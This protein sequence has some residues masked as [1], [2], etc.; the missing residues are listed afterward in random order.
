MTNIIEPKA[1]KRTSARHR[2][3]KGAQISFRGLHAAIDCVV[4]DTSDGGA[5]LAVES[6]VG[7]PDRFDLVRENL[8]TKKCQVVWRHATQ[9]GAKFI[10]EAAE[11]KPAKLRAKLSSP[12]E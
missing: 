11:E 2:I 5:R 1:E 9:I 12:P 3:F 8:P 6:S 7:V 10:L 4:R